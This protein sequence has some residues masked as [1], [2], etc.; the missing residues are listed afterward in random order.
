MREGGDRER[1]RERERER[2]KRGEIGSV[3]K[4]SGSVH[5]CMYLLFDVSY[6][7]CT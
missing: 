5:E 6:C 7:H 1:E 4:L 2:G 3:N